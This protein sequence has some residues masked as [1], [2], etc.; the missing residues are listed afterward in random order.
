MV[1]YPNFDPNDFATPD[2]GPRNTRA[3]SA[4]RCSRSSTARSARRRRP[5]RRSR[6]SRAARRSRRR[7]RHEPGAL[8]QRRVEL[9]RP[10]FRD[11]AAGGLGTTDFVHALAASSDGYF[12]QLGDRLGHARLRYY[13]LQYGLDNA[14]ASTCPASSRQ[15]A[16]Q[17]VVDEDLRSLPPRTER[18]LPTRDRPRRDAGDAAADGERHRRHRQRRDPLPPPRRRGGPRSERSRRSRR[19][20]HEIVRH[21]PVT[22]EA[23]REVARGWRGHRPGGPAYGMAVRA[24]RT[25]ARRN[26]RD[27]GAARSEHDLV[28]RLRT[29]S[30]H[31][32]SSRSPCLWR[33]RAA[34]VRR[35]RRRSRA[36]SSRAISRPRPA[37]RRKP[38]QHTR[39]PGAN[40]PNEGAMLGLRRR[41][42]PPPL[43]P[44][45]APRVPSTCLRERANSKLGNASCT[46][47]SANPTST[48]RARQGAPG[49]AIEEQPL[50]LLAVGRHPRVARRDCGVRRALPR[51]EP[52]DS[53]E[54]RGR[55]RREADHLEPAERTPDPGDEMLFADPAYPAYESVRLSRRE[56]D[57]GTA[58][59]G[60]DFRLDLDELA[61]KITPKTQVLVINSPHN[62]TGGIL[63]SSDLKTIADLAQRNDFGGPPT[64]STRATLR[65]E[66]VSIAALPGMRDARSSSTASRKPTR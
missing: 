1:S 65:C 20:E 54:R 45:S 43:H 34:T 64:K 41:S 56:A 46:W 6:W 9:P 58:G 39:L 63:T 52:F 25:A 13:A 15:L 35:S 27:R 5:V 59:R 28:R 22:Q 51:R 8:R 23:L 3:I 24:C 48:R 18:R 16:D 12:Y 7:D 32:K 49:R 29:R 11:I 53:R 10:L 47:R 4:I 66:F 36:T 30:K 31:P 38:P 42:P 21:V 60:K 61:A 33:R 40:V 2:Q 37:P 17:R 19:F 55:G 14:S 62:P 50:A 44:A 57:S 26:G